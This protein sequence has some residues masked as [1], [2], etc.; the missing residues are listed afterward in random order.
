MSNELAEFKSLI[1]QLAPHADKPEF[2]RLLNEATGDLTKEKRFLLKME[3][4]RLAKP[5]IRAIDLRMRISEQCELISFQ[6]IT[7]Y[8]HAPAISLFE[9]LLNRYGQYT[10]GVYEAVL[11]LAEDEQRGDIFELS[12]SNDFIEELPAGRDDN[13]LVENIA[14]LD[15]EHR[16]EERMN[17]VVAVELFFES[18]ESIFASSIDIGTRGLKLKLKDTDQLELIKAKSQVL[19]VFRGFVPE[20]GLNKE[21]IPYKVIKVTG[22]SEQ[23]RIHLQRSLEDGPSDFNEYVS[24]LI[25]ANKRRYKVNL[26]NVIDALE[27]KIYEQAYSST[28]PALSVFVDT[29]D[30]AYPIAKYAC[31]N[32]TNKE[33][34]DYWLDENDHQRIGYLLNPKRIQTLVSSRKNKKHSWI[35]AFTH[36]KD[37]KVYFYSAS[38]AELE[39]NIDLKQVFLSYASRR[40]SWRVYHLSYQDIDHKS[41]HVKSSVPSGI[42]RKIDKLNRPLTA[43]LE[44]KLQHLSLMINIADVTHLI[45]Q[46]CYQKLDLERNKVK[47]LAVFGHA[48][49]KPPHELLSFRYKQEELRKETRYKLRTPVKLE[50]Y[51]GAAQ[52]VSEDCSVSGLKVELDEPFESRINSKISASFPELQTKT[53]QFL[54][55]NL[56]YRVRHISYDKLVLHLEAISEDELSVAEQFFSL[57]IRSNKDKLKSVSNEETVPGMGH[58]L[59]CLQASYSADFCVYLIKQLGDYYPIKTSMQHRPA[60]WMNILLHDTPAHKVNLSWLFQDKHKHDAFVR[61]ALRKLRTEPRQ[62][63]AELF[64]FF[65]PKEIEYDK[66]V[67]ARWENELATHR[68]KVQF[69]R[70]AQEKGQ[71]FAFNVHVNRATK[72][73]TSF[74]DQELQYLSRYAIH[75]AKQLEEHMWDI[76][77]QLFLNEVTD[78]V[79][80]R[81]LQNN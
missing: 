57:L 39:D 3:M 55:E 44:S 75:R 69:I 37:G 59:R 35:Y 14:L 24:K 23:A 52:A 40:V 45:G 20:S 22:H 16:C 29:K 72:P 46:Q 27:N 49:N 74:L 54:L 11:S 10:F 9:N 17:Y 21:A 80:Y 70:K 67:E 26:D 4:R 15:V 38:Q 60:K 81:Y 64:I 77:G 18:G 61:E 56:K 32:G 47:Q 66:A 13:Y 62:V 34:L 76:A 43:R 42:T 12:A 8:L 30:H 1:N 65:D 19:I 71:F 36:I 68:S 63:E 31:M 6:G 73:D 78:E 48:R 53:N 50:N 25:K 33:I 28:T 5:C 7:H 79:L 2:N 41:A 51:N 58:A